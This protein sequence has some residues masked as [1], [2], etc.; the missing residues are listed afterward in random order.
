MCPITRTLLKDIWNIVVSMGSDPK[1]GPIFTKFDVMGA[2]GRT[3]SY[4]C[5][6]TFPIQFCHL[7]AHLFLSSETLILNST[8]EKFQF[9]LATLILQKS[10]VNNGVSGWYCLHCAV[11]STRPLWKVAWTLSLN[12]T[13][14]TESGMNQPRLTGRDKRCQNKTYSRL[15]MCGSTEL[16]PRHA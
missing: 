9:K 16:R 2:C 13:L 11:S 12:W 10:W 14:S 4:C 15:D 7:I 6:C 1:R 8:F 3:A 5:L